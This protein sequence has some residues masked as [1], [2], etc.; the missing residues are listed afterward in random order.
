MRAWAAPLILLPVASLLLVT[1]AAI[2]DGL[3]CTGNRLT[4]EG[5]TIDYDLLYRELDLA[6]RGFAQVQLITP[7]GANEYHGGGW[8][9]RR[10]APPSSEVLLNLSR[11]ATE[12]GPFP[13][14]FKIHVTA[15]LGGPIG[16]CRALF[17]NANSPTQLGVGTANCTNT[18]NLSNCTPLSRASVHDTAVSD[19]RIRL[20]GEPPPR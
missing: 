12:G 5:D 18:L 7:G 19:L 8:L 13:N 14:R 6:G 3:L 1:G 20:Q 2:A 10:P 9:A 16:T 17:Y 15:T 4:I 11:R